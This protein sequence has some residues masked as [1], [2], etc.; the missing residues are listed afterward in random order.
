[1]DMLQQQC[2]RLK[3]LAG[4]PETEA[5]RNEVLLALT[6]KWDGVRVNAAKVLGSWGG[7]AN[8]AVLLHRYAETRQ[9]SGE[10]SGIRKALCLAVSD[11]DAHWLIDCC[12]KPGLVERSCAIEMLSHLSGNVLH[13]ALARLNGQDDEVRH[14]H[15]D[16][17]FRTRSYPDRIKSLQALSSDINPTIA[18]RARQYLSWLK[19]VEPALFNTEPAKPN[20]SSRGK[21]FDRKFNRAKQKRQL[22]IRKESM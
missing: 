4:K 22:A 10:R 18:L 15:C 7:P 14:L 13:Q 8:M 3:F 21:A 12:F 16:L 19:W 17:L 6:S 1:M 9:Y 11:N 5:A 2:E 20:H